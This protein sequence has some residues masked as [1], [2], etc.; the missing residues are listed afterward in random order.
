MEVQCIVMMG[1][2]QAEMKVCSLLQRGKG[3]LLPPGTPKLFQSSVARARAAKF[4]APMC[5]LAVDKLHSG[6]AHAIRKSKQVKAP[7]VLFIPCRGC[8]LWR[9]EKTDVSRALLVCYKSR[10]AQ[11]EE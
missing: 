4:E 6:G 7:F 10:F 9:L 1:C 11:D 3:S 2:L 8:G 5:K